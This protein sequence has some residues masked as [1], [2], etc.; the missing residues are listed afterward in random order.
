M[1]SLWELFGETVLWSSSWEC[2]CFQTSDLVLCTSLLLMCKYHNISHGLIPRQATKRLQLKVY[3]SLQHGYDKHASPLTSLYSCH[4][5]FPFDPVTLFISILSCYAKG[6]FE[7]ALH[8]F[9]NKVGAY[10]NN[11]PSKKL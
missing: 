6:I 1:S 9:W 3:Q 10:V 8:S 11:Y 5:Y 2:L 4:Q 7:N